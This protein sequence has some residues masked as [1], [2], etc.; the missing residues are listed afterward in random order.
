MLFVFQKDDVEINHNPPDTMKPAEEQ[1]VTVTIDKSDVQGFAKYQVTLADGISAEVVE[2]AGAS[3]TFNNGKAKFIW[4][5]LPQDDE[6]SIKYRLITTGAA[7]GRKAIDS[8]F[9]YIYENE[10]KNFDLPTH[11]IMIGSDSQIADSSAEDEDETADAEVPA[12][13]NAAVAASRTIDS[14]GINQWKVNVVIEKEYLEGFGKVEEIIPEGYTA[15]DFKSSGAVFSSENDVVKYIWYDIPENEK[16]IVTYKLLPVIAM[17]GDRPDIKGAFSYLQEDKT[18]EIPILEGALAK[19]VEK[20]TAGAEVIDEEIAV[21]EE[22]EKV[23]KDEI[24]EATPSVE[25]EI[26]DPEVFQE[27]EAEARPD[28]VEE[29]SL[30]AKAMDE[31]DEEEPQKAEE[32]DSEKSLVDANIVDVPEP[33]EGVFYRVQIAAAKNS[34][35][36]PVFEKLYNFKEGF[37]LETHKGWFKYTTGYHQ[38]YKSARDDRERITAKYEKFRGPF[39]AAYN[40]G[41]RITVQEALMITDQR[42][43]P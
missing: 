13:T 16:V 25:E 35:T 40:D 14:D 18:I 8:R 28:I 7:T 17:E 36:R 11:Y 9:S 27:E 23:E 20:D 34:V 2:S 33:E 42:W 22:S 39:V 21:V 12:N 1:V 6:F 37:N 4:M 29:E 38:V 3:F 32:E 31:A 41:D 15:I 43:Y 5:A 26:E 24:E 10:R 19:T 30:T